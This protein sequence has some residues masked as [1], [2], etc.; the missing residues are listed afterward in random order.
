[1]KR[2]FQSSSASASAPLSLSS[3]LSPIWTHFRL[4][5]NAQDAARIR[6]GSRFFA[7]ALPA[8]FFTLAPRQIRKAIRYCDWVSVLSRLIDY[9][10]QPRDCSCLFPG[11]PA[12]ICLS[13]SDGGQWPWESS[14]YYTFEFVV[15]DV[16]ACEKL[17]KV[18]IISNDEN[19]E[20][21]DRFWLTLH[22]TPHI[23]GFEWNWSLWSEVGARD[24]F[25]MEQQQIKGCGDAETVLAM[26][27]SRF[28]TQS[29]T[30]T[31]I[32]TQ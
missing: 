16:K 5:L 7:H 12:C 30:P 28:A 32:H 11:D 21:E 10:I 20:Y 17:T 29:D 15:D 6:R 2:Q 24:T 25:W 8:K 23:K 3:S 26:I 1:M 13:I 22:M 27:L 14:T 18:G 19:R 31:P 4:F 9:R